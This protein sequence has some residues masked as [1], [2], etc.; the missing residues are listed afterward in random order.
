MASNSHN[1]YNTPRRQN[2]DVP[3]AWEEDSLYENIDFLTQ[4]A[5]SSDTSEDEEPL[6]LGRETGRGSRGSTRPKTPRGLVRPRQDADN[7]SSDEGFDWEPL[8]SFT[9]QPGAF[10]FLEP[11]RL[12][13]SNTAS[14]L[15]SSCSDFTILGSSGENP[16][17]H[18]NL[19]EE[20]MYEE[21][22]P[23]A[24]NP[25][26]ERHPR[27]LSG[28]VAQ[29][30]IRKSPR[31]LKFKPAKFKGLSSSLLNPFTA[32]DSGRR[33]RRQTPTC[34]PGFTP[35]FQ[36]LGE[37]HYVKACTVFFEGCMA[38][39]KTTLLNFARQT[40]SDDEA[41][42]IPEPMRFWTEVYTNVLS[43]IVKINKEC[44]PGKTSTT[45][46]LV[47][48]QLK[49]ATPLKTQSLFLQRSVKKDSEM[50]PVGPL[51][52]WVIVDR[53]QLSALV[54]FP[55]VLM[56][57]GMLSFSDFFNL[58]GM[59]E[60]HPGEVIALMSVNVEENFTRLKKRGRVCERH[61]DRDY[62]KEIKGS[63]NAAYCAWLFLQYFSIQTTMQICMG[64]SS[65]D[66]ACATEGVCHTTAS[67][68]WN[69]S[70]LVTLSDII[71]QFSND[72]TVQ[73][74]CYNFFSQLSTLKFVVIDLSAFRHDVP[75]AWGEFYMQVMKNGDIKTRVMDFTA[76]KALADTAHNTHASL[77]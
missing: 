26:D 53:H 46:E 5:V 33:A 16:T 7:P 9:S 41:L 76:I 67:R 3:K 54:V 32:S 14:G 75:G 57:R 18:A 42:T 27:Q 19:S 61:I 77:D 34:Q 45:A 51:D 62:I 43:Q 74:V 6:P 36:D 56:R 48:C 47:S 52:K 21:I 37:P 59:F 63:F 44:K 29:G 15:R 71:S 65:L 2:Y 28:A 22:P 35:I 20:E 31:K 1:N 25:S 30:A 13:S 50:Q 8:E 64:L 70:M 69:N 58:L 66:E 23:L 73:N 24:S 11:P 17:S 12:S 4:P 55:L 60:A 40:L 38:A 39:G 68:I 10:S 72:Y 49:F